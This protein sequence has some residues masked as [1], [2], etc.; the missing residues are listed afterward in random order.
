MKNNDVYSRMLKCMQRQG[1]VHN[2]F[3]MGMATVLSVNPVTIS[4]NNTTISS[5]IVL[6]NCIQAADDAEAVISGEAGIS[7][8]LKSCLTGMLHTMKLQKGDTVIVQ[9]V[10]N[11]F[12]LV[13]KAG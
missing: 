7:A 9:R 2:G 10:G 13:G 11:L 12:Y 3:D 5:G 6:G 1:K 4:Y 8:E